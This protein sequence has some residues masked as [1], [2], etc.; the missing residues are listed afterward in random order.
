[1][2]NILKIDFKYIKKNI[3]R[4]LNKTYKQIY[5]KRKKHN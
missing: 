5:H 3:N 1:M 4:K 2:C